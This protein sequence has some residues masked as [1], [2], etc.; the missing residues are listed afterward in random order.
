[1]VKLSNNN[2]ISVQKEKGNI[3]FEFCNGGNLNIFN[4]YILG[5]NALTE[6][7]IQKIVKQIVE[8]L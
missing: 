6:I 2:L 5:K 1:M 8:G 7:H 3:F 4:K